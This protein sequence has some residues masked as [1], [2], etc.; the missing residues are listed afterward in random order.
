MNQN[1]SFFPSL[2][3]S[4]LA[5]VAVAALI[6]GTAG[7]RAQDN[8]AA[9]QQTT[10]ASAQPQQSATLSNNSDNDK[11]GKKKENK[12]DK[13]VQ[14]KDTKKRL[15][16]EKKNDELAATD[17][18]LPDRQLYDKA[19]AATK[20]GHFDVARLDLQTL[21]NTYPDSQY[22][23]KAKL[24]IADSWYREGGSAALTQAEQEYK[25]FITFFPNVPEAAEAQMR[26]GD[27]YF[28]QMDKPDRDYTK[29]MHAQEEYRLMLQQFPE[30]TLV[31][32]AKQRLREVQEVLATREAEIGAYYATRENW[33]A[34]I[35]RYQ[36]VADTYP[37]YSHMDDVLI[38]LGDAYE[39]EARI[40]RLQKQLPSDARGRLASIY[41]AHA[42]D[43][44]RKV[45]LEHSA[46][47][48]VEDARDRLA[49]MNIPIPTPTPE[50]VAAS[51]ALENSR[52]QYSLQSRAMLMVLRRPDVVTAARLGDP[53]MNDA[54]PTMAPE[55]TKG[56]IKDYQTAMNPTAAPATSAEKPAD[57]TPSTAAAD[58][59]PAQP[60]APA[61]P[62]TPLAFQDIPSA[63]TGSDGASVMSNVPST[64]G[65]AT[66][67]TAAP[68]TSGGSNAM[69]VEIL[70]PGA[71]GSSTPA[72]P[73]PD[74]N[75][76]LKAVGPTNTEAAPAI[77]KP[78]AAPDAINDVNAAEQPKA[79]PTKTG[80]KKTPK[81][82]YDNG[83]ESS[84]THKKKKGL[85]KLNP[86]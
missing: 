8:G 3:A 58:T 80:D 79:Q 33:P 59:T 6:A 35:A 7:A 21:L 18:K 71:N 85:G 66:P 42:A 16:S 26:V 83:E 50:Q 72:Q 22:Q 34:T 41:E 65:A 74:A 55:V 43:A 20:K 5:G 81:P 4:L 64:G 56:I 24:A 32:Q 25:D 1:R 82:S 67:A 49:A 61:K 10:D 11:K 45:A 31:P 2:K 29:S 13:V 30:S 39:S 63:G 68:A 60:A 23:M 75:G 15:A 48:H 78:A 62:A 52:G 47:P 73:A 28:R 12:E 57:A 54:K 37:L 77:E 40:A 51:T 76:G 69:G 46:S 36:T 84:S 17:A 70:T 38:A 44:Y 86:F 27:I 9:A 53:S 14:S 19:L